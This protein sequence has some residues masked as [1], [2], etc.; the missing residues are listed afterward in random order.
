R[1]YAPEPRTIVRA[2]PAPVPTLEHALAH[3]EREPLALETPNQHALAHVDVPEP[4][5][6]RERYLVQVTISKS[7]HD[8]LRYAQELL[9]H[10]LPSGDVARVLDRAL[11]SLIAQL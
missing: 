2:I 6:A 11:D 4:E 10:A 1:F 9:G 8:K 5:Q 3:V 7:T